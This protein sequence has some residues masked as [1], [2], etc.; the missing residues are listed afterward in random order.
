MGISIVKDLK[1]NILLEIYIYRVKNIYITK[2]E[3]FFRKIMRLCRRDY[4]FNK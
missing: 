2:E 3:K 4:S 1:E